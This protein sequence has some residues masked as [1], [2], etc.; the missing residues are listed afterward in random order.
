ML[1]AAQSIK[2]RGEHH[3]IAATRSRLQWRTA[4]GAPASAPLRLVQRLAD[5][6]GEA[7]SKGEGG[8]ERGGEKANFRDVRHRSAA[9]PISNRLE[10]NGFGGKPH[11]HFGVDRTRADRRL[12]F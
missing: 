5:H 6:F 10:T 3:C 9:P 4:T 7:R 2:S 12:C 11:V 1:A 8:D